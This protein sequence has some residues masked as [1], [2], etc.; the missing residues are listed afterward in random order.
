MGHLSLLRDNCHH[1][2]PSK[3][4]GLLKRLCPRRGNLDF[5]FDSLKRLCI[6]LGEKQRCK[7]DL[8]ELKRKKKSYPCPTCLLQDPGAAKGNRQG[9]V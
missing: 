6:V 9:E 8:K 5:A 7:I 2:N 3:G 4:S 1:Q